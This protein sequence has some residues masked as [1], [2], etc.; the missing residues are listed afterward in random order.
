MSP[1]RLLR[2]GA[3]SPEGYGVVLDKK[4]CRV[5]G[6]KTEAVVMDEA[7]VG[8]HPEDGWS[9]GSKRI[10][11]AGAEQTR[12]PARTERSNLVS[13]VPGI[14]CQQERCMERRRPVARGGSF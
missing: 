9:V 1:R 7:I 2:N 11:T 6:G 13:R 14:D 12:K 3:K 8:A 10:N 5:V 4:D